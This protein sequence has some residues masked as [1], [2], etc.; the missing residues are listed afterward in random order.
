MPI[1]HAAASARA[2]KGWE[3][4]RKGGK[5]STKKRKSYRSMTEAELREAERYLPY[6]RSI[7]SQLRDEIEAERKRRQQLK[8]AKEDR[9]RMKK[10][11]DAERE[12]RLHVRGQSD[13]AKAPV[14]KALKNAEAA[15]E[16][17]WTV[18]TMRQR[19]KATWDD[20]RDAETAHRLAQDKHSA[21]LSAYYEKYHQHYV[22]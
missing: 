22:N 19:G 17:Y 20:V 8:H 14:R 18:V 21:A 10:A 9:E 2:R 1:S 7:P 13:R 5:A 11:R 12:R 15:R 3:T 16:H 4:R 6:N